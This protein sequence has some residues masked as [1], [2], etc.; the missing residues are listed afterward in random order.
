MTKKMLVIY[1]LQFLGL[2]VNGV[3]QNLI[4]DQITSTVVSTWDREVL[5]SIQGVF[6]VA[7]AERDLTVKPVASKPS[8]D[9]FTVT[10]KDM[11]R[12]SVPTKEFPQLQ[13]QHQRHRT[14]ERHSVNSVKVKNP[15]TENKVEYNFDFIEKYEKQSDQSLINVKGNLR[16][17]IIILEKCS[18]S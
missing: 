16:K 18:F 9:V 15:V 5:N 7:S 12:G 11:L 6:V 2:I 3:R 14:A 13:Q 1:V 8:E 10:N 4:T 17:K